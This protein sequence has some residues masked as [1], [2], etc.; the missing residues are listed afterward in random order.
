MTSIRRILLAASL[1][2]SPAVALDAQ[3]TPNAPR[4][5]SA[6]VAAVRR[7]HAQRLAAMVRKQWALLDTLL[8]D[9]LTYGHA[10]GRV[11]SKAT[12]MGAMRNGALVYERLEPQI[13]TVAAMDSLAL[14]RGRG[15]LTA[16]AG[17]VVADQTIVYLAAY[18]LQQGRWKLTA[19]QS[20]TAPSVSSP[21]PTGARPPESR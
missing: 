9:D 4:P 19:W 1:V 15:R 6:I 11:D 13:E 16:R 2:A 21:R 20:T 17:S 10:T 18:R 8:A 7:D 14:V 5:D 3:A 12:L